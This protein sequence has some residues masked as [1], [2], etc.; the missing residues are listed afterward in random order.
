M[1]RSVHGLRREG[2]GSRKIGTVG[3]GFRLLT[4][5]EKHRLLIQDHLVPVH[6]VIPD[7][8]T[9]V[10]C[11]QIDSVAPLIIQAVRLT[12]QAVDAAGAR[13]DFPQN[14]LLIGRFRVQSQQMIPD[15]RVTGFVLLVL[16]V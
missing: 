10:Q 13:C 3:R 16:E 2:Q 6:A 14:L 8:Q 7:H 1:Q 15:R 11:F 4:G 5:A 12:G 9:A